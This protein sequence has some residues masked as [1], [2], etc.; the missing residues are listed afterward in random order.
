MQRQTHAATFLAVATIALALGVAHVHGASGAKNKRPKITFL[1]VRA[2]QGDVRRCPTCVG[3]KTADD[4]HISLRFRICDD[5][6]GGIDYGKGPGVVWF[7]TILFERG[8]AITREKFREPT[9]AFDRGCHRYRWS[10]ALPPW[11]YRDGRIVS[12]F[13]VRDPEGRW[14]KTVKRKIDAPVWPLAP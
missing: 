12:F 3:G 5:S 8:R 11:F 2:H 7:K 1:K 6:R 13:R 14:S 9:L 10:F 4:P